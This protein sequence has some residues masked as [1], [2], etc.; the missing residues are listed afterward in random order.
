MVGFSAS[1]SNGFRYFNRALC[2][3][4]IHRVLLIVGGGCWLRLAKPTPQNNRITDYVFSCHLLLFCSPG[5]S[6]ASLVFG[7]EWSRIF[8]GLF[9]VLMHCD[10]LLVDDS[11]TGLPLFCCIEAGRA[12]NGLDK[13]TINYNFCASQLKSTIL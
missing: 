11:W 9:L 2:L 1:P 7:V 12:I 10:V 6:V 3:F 8:N 5:R 4:A 13:F